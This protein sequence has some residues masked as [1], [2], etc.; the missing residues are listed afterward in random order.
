M[1]G[2][3]SHKFYDLK[4]LKKR[5]KIVIDLEQNRLRIK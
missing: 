4:N 3:W 2:I 5:T 1:S